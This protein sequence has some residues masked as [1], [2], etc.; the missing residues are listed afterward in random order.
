MKAAHFTALVVLHLSAIPANAAIIAGPFDYSGNGHH[1]YLLAPTGWVNSENEAV[2][3][4]GHLV[5]INDLSEN[6]WVLDT[7]G[8]LVDALIPA[9]RDS[10]PA[11]WTGLSDAAVEG[12][13]MWANGDP[14][15][16]T[17]WDTGQPNNS[18]GDQDYVT[19]RSGRVRNPASDHPGFWNDYN[20][21]NSA[22][23]SEFGVVEIVPEPSCFVLAGIGL[24]FLAIRRRS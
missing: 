15:L 16:F 10:V 11:L 6:Q 21:F 20:D 17:H 14:V 8:P 7:F 4:G 3:L 13:Y 24:A 2:S 18:G 19:M 5:A 9:P 12:T 22:I 23:G 1:Y